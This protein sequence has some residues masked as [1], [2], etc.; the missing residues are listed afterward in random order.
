MGVRPVWEESSGRVVGVQAIPLE[1]LKRPRIDVTVRISG[2]FRDT[3]PNVVHLIDDA[4]ALILSLNESP[5]KN[6]V[7]KHVTTEVQ[8]R[9]TQGENVDVA[10][11][12]ASYRVFGDRPGAYGCGVSE[13]IDSKNWKTQQDLSD[14]YVTW[15]SYAYSRKTYG[16]ML[17]D[18]FK[19]RLSSINLT[20]KNQDSRE[21]DILD[22]DDWYDAHGGMVNA[23]KVIGGKAPRSYCGDS[24]DPNRVKVRSTKEETCQVF[25][26]R[27]L[28]PKWIQSLKPHGYAGASD[29]SRTLDFVF[30]W[31]AT[32]EVVE[33]WMYEG[34]AN[35]YVL[36]AKMQQWLKD[37]NPYALQNMIERLLEAIERGM[38]QA[39]EELK[40]QLQQLYLQTEGLLENTNEKKQTEGNLH[41]RIE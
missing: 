15:G 19:R 30:G 8:Q 21:Y 24:S 32:V 11:E 1:E 23:V 29:L 34:L 7:A 12:E 16:Q 25:R 9:L 18:Q 36:D 41:K 3:F 6:F 2:L 10:R 37:V 14:V 35:K 4:V 26:S 39:P 13:L 33:D 27:L 38:W 28:N 40:K 31:D 22:G 20:V 5:D 17:P